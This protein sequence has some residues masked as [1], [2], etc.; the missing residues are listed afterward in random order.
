MLTCRVDF[1]HLYDE[2]RVARLDVGGVGSFPVF[3]GLGNLVNRSECSFLENATVPPGSYWIVD[4]PTGGLR[5][6]S[7]TW[8]KHAYTGNNHYDWFALFRK[9]GVVD[10]YMTFDVDRRHHYQRGHFRLHPPRPDGSGISE[11][12]ITF[13]LSQDFYRVRAALL[14]AHRH[15]IL[16]GDQLWAYG[17]ITVIGHTRGDCRV[18]PD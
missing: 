10:D 13:F 3:S 6:R 11:G 17:E 8:F 14:K 18:A 16:Q 2:G 1:N 15:R 9:D 7:E 12:C 5:S 4:R